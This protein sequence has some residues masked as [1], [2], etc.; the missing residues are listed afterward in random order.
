MI[1]GM[2]AIAAQVTTRSNN[3]FAGEHWSQAYQGYMEGAAAEGLRA[4]RAGRE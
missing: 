4:T 2:P 1:G 3:H